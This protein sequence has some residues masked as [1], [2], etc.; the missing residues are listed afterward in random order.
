MRPRVAFG[1]AAGFYV[2]LTIA[3]TWPLLLHPGSRVPNDLGDS[4]LNMFILAW[5]AR[6]V[7]L[8]PQ[9]WQLSQFYP[10][11]GAMAF[12]EHLLG[13]SIITTPIILATGNVLLAYNTAFF[14]SF[15]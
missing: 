1:L 8:L 2:L 10:I 5:D 9:W 13:L 7:P 14:L 11:A 4:L 6:K 3:L 15:P 12:S